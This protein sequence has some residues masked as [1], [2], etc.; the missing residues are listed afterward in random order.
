MNGGKK[1]DAQFEED[2]DRWLEELEQ[3]IESTRRSEQLTQKDYSIRIN[4]KD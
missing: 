3:E 1:T 4:A 2:F